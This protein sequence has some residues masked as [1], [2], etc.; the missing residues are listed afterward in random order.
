VRSVVVLTAICL[1]YRGSVA[2]NIK[3]EQ[4]GRNRVLAVFV[5]RSQQ[6]AQSRADYMAHYN[7][8]GH[9]PDL[10]GDWKQLDNATF[11]GV[12]WA[13]TS[14][15]STCRPSGRSSHKNDTSRVLLGDAIAQ[16]KHGYFRVRIW[17]K[18]ND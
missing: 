16:S 10:A 15:V 1:L 12:G 6:I 18:A 5:A 17:G 13:R 11:E 14:L 9:P 3:I 2:E 8:R 4:P 7:L